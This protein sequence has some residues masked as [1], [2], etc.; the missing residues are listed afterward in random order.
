MKVIGRS[1][2]S[3]Q[4]LTSGHK[5]KGGGIWRA[6]NDNLGILLSRVHL[7]LKGKRETEFRD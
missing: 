7:I 6:A 3:N 2:D 1:S 4:K 5:W